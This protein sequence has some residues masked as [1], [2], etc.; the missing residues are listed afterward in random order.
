M[1]SKAIPTKKPNISKPKAIPEHKQ[2]I[3]E[4]LLAFRRKIS[5]STKQETFDRELTFS[6][7]ETLMFIGLHDKKSMESIAS[8]LKIA[9]PSATSLIEKLEKKG[10][11]LRTKDKQDRRMVLIE[12]SPQAK[13]QISNMWDR[14]EQVLEK[15]ISKLNSTDRNHFVRIMKNLIED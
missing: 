1:S 14:K 15:L 5:C 12:L 2:S 3:G 11:I 10:L 7:I 8:Y 6:Q 4:L 13:K 9:P